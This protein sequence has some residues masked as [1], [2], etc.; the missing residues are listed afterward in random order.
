MEIFRTLN[1]NIKDEDIDW[2]YGGAEFKITKKQIEALLNGQ[3][4]YGTINDEYAFTI[5][6]EKETL[7]IE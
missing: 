1:K 2:L 6:L 3:K 7:E 4:L 5:E